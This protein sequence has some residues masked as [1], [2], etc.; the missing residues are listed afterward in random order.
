MLGL[1]DG[2]RPLTFDEVSRLHSNLTL[3]SHLTK[4]NSEHTNYSIPDSQS[5]D[6]TSSETSLA[7]GTSDY[8]G[9]TD[10]FSFSGDSPGS[11]AINSPLG[12][13]YSV[14]HGTKTSN[15]QKKKK[16]KTFSDRFIPSRKGSKLHIAFSDV[17]VQN[18]QEN[19]NP[20]KQHDQISADSPA[21]DPNF[22]MNSLYRTFVLGYNPAQSRPNTQQHSQH[23]QNRNLLRY[24]HTHVDP[25]LQ[26]INSSSVL[27]DLGKFTVS[28][29]KHTRKIPKVPYK[30]LDA[31][32]LQDDF[33]LNLID[34]SAQNTLAVGLSSCVYLWSAQF[35]RVTK[36]CDL[37]ISDT[38]TSVN[39][40]PKGHHLSVGTNSGEVQIW[41][42]V[43]LKKVRVMGGH[44]AR[45]GAL[46]WNSSVLTSGS[47]DK[48]HT[49][50]R[51]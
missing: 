36:L 48:K 46:G 44:T 15:L 47:R 51:H 25:A 7:G 21:E 50:S 2:S 11:E 20:Y 41:D 14:E 29:Q 45:V 28:T 13:Q 1:F 38:I 35:S 18:N 49:L 26:E 4:Q 6:E 42:P 9:D 19:V 16:T 32:A 34:W 5:T 24:S 37:G 23:F 39:W 10:H 40:A 17:H 43:K 30:V 33:Y 8:G 27:G 31:P 3:N 12:R 22:A